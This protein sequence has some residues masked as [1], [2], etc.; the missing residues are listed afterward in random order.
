M[1]ITWLGLW[2]W[3][4]LWDCG[5]RMFPGRTLLGCIGWR[6]V[7]QVRWPFGCLAACLAGLDCSFSIS[8]CWH[9]LNLGLEALKRRTLRATCYRKLL[10]LASQK[11]VPA[12]VASFVFLFC[13]CFCFSN[14]SVFCFCKQSPHIIG[15]SL[16]LQS[17]TGLAFA[18]VFKKYKEKN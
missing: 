3:L 9:W 18:S 1:A 5:I 14:F 2:L 7:C 6:Y 12:A 11:P 16:C 15:L 10:L 13:F 17:K 4:W 8:L